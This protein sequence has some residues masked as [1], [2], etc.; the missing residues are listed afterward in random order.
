[1]GRIDV[2][3]SNYLAQANPEL[4]KK[5]R[6]SGYYSALERAVKKVWKEDEFAAHYVLA[7]INAFYITTDTAPVKKKYRDQHWAICT[8][9]IDDSLIRGDVDARQGLLKLALA[10]EG[11][12]FD[13]LRLLPSKFDMKTRHP[14]QESVEII[15]G[16]L[17]PGVQESEDPKAPE[18]ISEQTFKDAIGAVEDPG[19]AK[20]LAGAMAA[21]A[22]W[23]YDAAKG[24]GETCPPIVSLYHLNEKQEDLMTLKRAFFLTFGEK[25]EEVISRINRVYLRPRSFDAKRRERREYQT[26]DC[27]IYSC[28]PRLTHIMEAF[29]GTLISRARRLR[30]RIGGIHLY[31]SPSEMVND[32]AF[33]KDSAPIVWEDEPDLPSQ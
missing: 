33:P 5:L 14:F 32:R 20:K 29:G 11:I 23:A 24:S 22:A 2:E 21:S 25:T 18:P 8:I 15:D 12:H 4:A 9:C 30:L 26:Y 19:L 13:E 17:F 7:H 16:M 28:E 3:I 31:E 10:N 6:V 27:D 1:M